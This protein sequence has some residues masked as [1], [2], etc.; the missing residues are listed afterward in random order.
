[1]IN[2]HKFIVIFLIDSSSLQKRETQHLSQLAIDPNV[3]PSL[4]IHMKY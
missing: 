4:R 3:T 2:L 1:M